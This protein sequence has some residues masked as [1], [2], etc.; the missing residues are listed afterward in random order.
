M[1][2]EYKYYVYILASE[3][4]G[5]LYVG[6]TNNLFNRPFQ[7]KLKQNKDSFTAKH[8]VNKLVYYEITPNINSAIQREK[9]IKKWRREK[10]N[11]LIESLNPNWSDL[12]E[13]WT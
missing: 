12:S 7:H 6:V 11:N 4:N 9:E 1:K 13:E 5:T 3:R 8:S 10:K 2:R